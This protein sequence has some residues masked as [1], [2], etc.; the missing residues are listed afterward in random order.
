MR[1]VRALAYAV[2]APAATAACTPKGTTA[3]F[4][5]PQGKDES[6]PTR[7]TEAAP[8]PGADAGLPQ[9]KM[10][11]P[12]QARKYMLELINRDR[13]SA[14]LAPVALEQA[15]ASRAGQRH[16]EDMAAHGYTGHFGTDGSVPEQRYTEA[17]GADMVL[18]NASCFEDEHARA[19]DASPRID[20]R[21][22]DEIERMFIGEKPPNDGHRKNILTAR[23]TKVGIGLAQPK[24]TLHEIPSPCVSQEFV[25]GYGT[26]T[27][28]PRQVRVGASL[29][30]E[31]SISAPATFAGIGLARV[32]A[33]GPVDVAELNRRRS[34]PVPPPYQSYWPAGYKTPIVVQT[35]G[36]QFKVDV[37]VDDRGK[38]GMYEVS[39]WA[40][41]PNVPE[42]VMVSLRTIMAR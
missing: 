38:S 35:A 9:G 24:A 15:A 18:E 23:H 31:G 28:V 36:A 21:Y 29:H 16:A 7:G 4:A 19:L 25:D 1:L 40:K 34:Y 42:L 5:P 39:V 17:G 20:A 41:V 10:L 32:E 27:T 3:P 6:A 2:I 13:A 33:P 26:Y 37:P 8:A 11:T 30:V 22:I 12:D 14:G